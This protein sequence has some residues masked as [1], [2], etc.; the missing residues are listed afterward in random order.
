MKKKIK[1]SITHGMQMYPVIIQYKELKI[2]L[3][4]QLIK[5]AGLTAEEFLSN[6]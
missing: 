6:L 5:D 4:H 3:L 1:K 2:G